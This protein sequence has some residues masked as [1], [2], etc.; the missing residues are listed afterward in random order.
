MK[1]VE[2]AKQLRKKQKSFEIKG[3]NGGNE[4][5]QT[6][7]IKQAKTAKATKTGAVKEDP[8]VDDEEVKEGDGDTEVDDCKNVKE[9]KVKQEEFY[10]LEDC[11]KDLTSPVLLERGRQGGGCQ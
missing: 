6:K 5:E 9:V 7:H 2:E 4:V 8:E 3:A 10:T 1:G 11:L